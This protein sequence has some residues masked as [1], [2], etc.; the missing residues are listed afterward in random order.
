M[1]YTIREFPP[2][3]E[4]PE[5]ITQYE[6]PEYNGYQIVMKLWSNGIHTLHVHKENPDGSIDTIVNGEYEYDCSLWDTE[7]HEMIEK[8]LKDRSNY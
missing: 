6:Y 8:V 1:S 3:P 2:P 5:V 7:I 4:V